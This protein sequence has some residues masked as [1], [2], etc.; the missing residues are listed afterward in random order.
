MQERISNARAKEELRQEQNIGKLGE[1]LLKIDS[2]IKSFNAKIEKDK[3]NLRE[4]RMNEQ[5]KTK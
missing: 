3:K 1:S 2:R 4:K 5:E